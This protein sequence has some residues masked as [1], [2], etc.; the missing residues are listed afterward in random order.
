MHNVKQ[1]A[2]G[3]LQFQNCGI[4]FET[5]QLSYQTPPKNPFPHFLL[6]VPV[7]PLKP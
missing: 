6:F 5:S 7:S 3:C 4:M 2:K 1:I